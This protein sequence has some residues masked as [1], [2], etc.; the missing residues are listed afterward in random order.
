L[1]TAA[2][3]EIINSGPKWLLGHLN[4]VSM[5]H[6][7]NYH[8]TDIWSRQSHCFVAAGNYFQLSLRS[9]W[10][11]TPHSF[12][13][14]PLSTATSCDSDL[15]AFPFTPVPGLSIPPI[16]N[17]HTP[18]F[19]LLSSCN[20]RN[21]DYLAATSFTFSNRSTRASIIASALISGSKIPFLQTRPVRCF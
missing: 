20:F 7:A 1:C 13:S 12:L 11:T 18:L 19:C 15:A 3:H 8:K 14:E 6:F 2:S 16:A 5:T 17:P 10:L 21:L 4:I 9:R